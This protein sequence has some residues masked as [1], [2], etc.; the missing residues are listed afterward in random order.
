MSPILPFWNAKGEVHQP[1]GAPEPF[2]DWTMGEDMN[3]DRRT[4]LY[5]VEEC[6]RS[7]SQGRA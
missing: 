1:E 4:L 5:R 3:E 7:E 2:G 6:Y